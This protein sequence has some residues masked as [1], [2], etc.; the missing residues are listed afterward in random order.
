MTIVR[1]VNTKLVEIVVTTECQ[2]WGNAQYSRRDTLEVVGIPTSIGDNVL[3][4]NVC[5]VFQEIGGDICNRD[6]QA[7]HFLKN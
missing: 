5:D 6:I 2:C 1:N 4:Q 3:E 7:Y